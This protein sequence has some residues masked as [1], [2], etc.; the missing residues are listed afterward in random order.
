MK[1]LEIAYG[2][3]DEGESAYLDLPADADSARLLG[4]RSVWA[5]RCGIDEET[6]LATPPG[7]ARASSNSMQR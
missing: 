3:E 7:A 4:G 6:G 5:P 2:S 1:D